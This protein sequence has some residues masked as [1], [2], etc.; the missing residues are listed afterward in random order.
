ML[1][2]SNQN[3]TNNLSSNSNVNNNNNINFNNNNNANNYSGQDN[4]N[5]NI[6]RKI[7]QN[8]TPNNV[9][10]P[11]IN[12]NNNIYNNIP[13]NTQSRDRDREKFDLQTPTDNYQKSMNSSQNDSILIEISNLKK[14]IKK[15]LENQ[16][17]A[18]TRIQDYS[19]LFSEQENIARIN[20]FK[21]NE[22]DSK[23]TEILMT[24]NNYLNLNDQSTKV[25]NDL[26]NNYEVLAKKADVADIKNKFMNFD[27][28]MD[29]KLLEVNGKY[30][31]LLIKYQEISK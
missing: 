31:D 29:S 20:N 12:E 13:R 3:K 21:L 5:D 9:F 24:F 10:L 4:T 7:R 8:M 28:I 15:L 27:K 1:A 16:T 23:I 2:R 26:S 19:K 6:G 30:E 18:Q 14:I 17:D 11:Q 25:I 22:H